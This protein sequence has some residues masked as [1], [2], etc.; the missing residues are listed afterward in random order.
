[1]SKA[2]GPGQ[3]HGTSRWA[4]VSSRGDRCICM[5]SRL[6]GLCAVFCLALLSSVVTATPA[7]A[8]SPAIS[9]VSQQDRHPAVTLAAPRAESVTVYIASKPDRATDGSFLQENVVDLDFLTDSEIQSGLWVDGSQLDPG[10]YFVMLKATR[11]FASCD[12]YDANLNEVIDPSCAD[13][14]STVVPL[15]V[16]TPTTKYTVKTEV[17]KNIGIAYLTLTGKPLGVKMPYQ[18]CWKQPTGRK[19]T[20]RT[21]CVKATLS[22][23]SWRADASDMLRINTKGMAR[24]TKFTWYARG[25][26]PNV[27]LSKTITVR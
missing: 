12:S 5:R 8:V 20:L 1:M 9:E 11:D 16:P 14:F 21:R 13:G 7:L 6:S 23:Y 27:L 18:V 3:A 24:R 25:G 2:A 10:P 26:T 19:K 15:T 22:G 4:Q 17:L